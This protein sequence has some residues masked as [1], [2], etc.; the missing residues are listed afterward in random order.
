VRR[1]IV[2]TEDLE[3]PREILDQMGDR[4]NREYRSVLLV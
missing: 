3:A 2:A 4:V 1:D